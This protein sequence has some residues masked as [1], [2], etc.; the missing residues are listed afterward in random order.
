L[1]KAADITSWLLMG[2]EDAAVGAQILMHLQMAQS[3]T[4]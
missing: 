4:V 3:K 2:A 1:A